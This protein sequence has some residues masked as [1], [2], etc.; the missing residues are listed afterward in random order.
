VGRSR[1]R[2]IARVVLAELNLWV[3][4]HRHVTARNN[5]LLEKITFVHLVINSQSLMEIGR[6]IT[7]F[8]K[9]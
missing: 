7:V 4:L 3:L 8:T 6:Y 1:L 9:V 2:P 5:I